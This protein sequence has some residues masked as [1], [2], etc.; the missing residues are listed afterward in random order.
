[1]KKVLCSRSAHRRHDG[2]SMVEMIGVLAIIA[3]LA[4]VIVPKVFSTIASARVTNTLAS[5]TSVKSAVTDF[6][7]KYG[8]IPTTGDKQRI[9]D[10]LITAGLLE[11]R[12]T[13]KLGTP[14][15]NP[16]KVGATWS[17]ANGSWTPSDTGADSQGAQS[18]I[19]CL[20][21]NTSA[22]AGGRNYRLNGGTTDLPAN[23]RV[24]SAVI[25]QVPLNDARE[26]SV[27]LDGEGLSQAAGATTADESGRVVYGATGTLRDVFIY[28]AHQ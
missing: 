12:F 9:D 25:R 15:S 20:T 18:R 2:F 3:I 11:S 8:T 28:I 7:G 23:S 5:V 1:M 14:P 26:L 19:V 13:V 6:A 21:S 10:L 4:V 16:P 27:R 24:V 22:P 17:V